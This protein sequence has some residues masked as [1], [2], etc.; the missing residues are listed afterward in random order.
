[1]RAQNDLGGHEA[2]A[3]DTAE[4]ELTFFEKRVD[5]LLRLLAD[6]PRSHFAIDAQRRVME[7]V[8]EG[9]YKKLS[10]YE[11]WMESIKRLAIEKGLVTHE[12]VAQRVAEI[13]AHIAA[14]RAAGAEG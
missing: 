1:M 6:P 2:G 3:I 10:Y 7:T 9:M 5:A 11:L 8:P 4:H 12:A 13:E 14:E